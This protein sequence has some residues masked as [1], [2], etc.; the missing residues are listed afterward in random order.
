MYNFFIFLYISICHLDYATLSRY[1]PQAELPKP[2]VNPIANRYFTLP[3]KK[4]FNIK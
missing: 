4:T 1:E 3:K 2:I